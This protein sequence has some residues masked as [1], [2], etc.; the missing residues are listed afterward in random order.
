MLFVDGRRS[1]T[2]PSQQQVLVLE[3]FNCVYRLTV[4]F[5]DLLPVSIQPIR[6]SVYEP[7]LLEQASQY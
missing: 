5:A 6:A 1:S 3:L 2:V 4:V 7:I